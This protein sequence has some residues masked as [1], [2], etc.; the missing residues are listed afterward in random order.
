MQWPGPVEEQRQ[1]QLLLSQEL[2]GLQHVPP[3]GRMLLVRLEQ[4]L[5]LHLS[6]M[7]AAWLPCPCLPWQAICR[8]D[9]STC[10]ALWQL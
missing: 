9:Q 3:G 8:S 10:A 6:S 7:R 4:V 1:P 2:Q 5:H